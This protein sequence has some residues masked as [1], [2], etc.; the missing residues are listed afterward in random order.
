MSEFNRDSVWWTFHFVNDW[1]SR[2][3]SIMKDDL[4]EAQ[5]KV[6][7]TTF[8]RVKEWETRALRICNLVRGCT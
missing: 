4:A 1:V 7:T 3:F 2:K 5:K 8:A 6:Q